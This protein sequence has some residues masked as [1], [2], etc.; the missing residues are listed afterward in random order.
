M[1]TGTLTDFQLGGF[2]RNT[3]NFTL[4]VANAQL[5]LKSHPT[6]FTTGTRSVT[7]SLLDMVGGNTINLSSVSFDSEAAMTFDGSDDI[8]N[9][10]LF[11]GRNTSTDPFTVEAWVKSDITSG[12]RMW[13]DATS[14]GSNQRFYS[15][16][17]DGTSS[18]SGIQG[19]GW[20]DSTPNHTNWSHQVIVMDGSTGHFYAD[21][22]LK[23]QMNYTSYTLAG[24]LN[25]GGRASYRWLG[26]ISMFKIYDR[27]LSAE[28]ILQNFNATRSRFGM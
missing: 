9:T 26:D 24:Q 3:S 17:I 5:E 21:G 11:N 15:S 8:I 23:Y 1:P 20:T 4:K 28:E 7:G 13:I 2:Y 16:L 10:G 25:I 18:A 19:T 22:Q 12:A 14:N 6:Q 27:A